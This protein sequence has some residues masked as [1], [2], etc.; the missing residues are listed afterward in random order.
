MDAAAIF[1]L[2]ENYMFFILRTDGE[3]ALGLR[4]PEKDRLQAKKRAAERRPCFEG[5]CYYLRIASRRGFT[6]LRAVSANS[7][8][9][10]YRL[11]ACSLMF[12][13]VSS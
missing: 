11:S 9:R 6:L 1:W 4:F 8:P 2:A 3:M 5:R 13:T 12:S 10:S 7:E